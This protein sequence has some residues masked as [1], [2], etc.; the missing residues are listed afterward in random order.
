MYA[1]QYY[2]T[3][4][5]DELTRV[6]IPL[7]AAH[8]ETSTITHTETMTR[9]AR[10]SIVSLVP[11]TIGGGPIG[12]AAKQFQSLKNKQ[13]FLFCYYFSVLIDQAVH[14]SLREE[15]EHF[16]TLHSYPKFCGFLGSYHHNLHPALLLLIA[17]LYPN[18]ATEHETIATVDL[19][20]GYFRKNYISFF[21]DAYP[22]HSGRLTDSHQR[23]LYSR[24]QQQFR[25]STYL[26]GG[27]GTSPSLLNR[28]QPRLRDNHDSIAGT[29]LPSKDDRTD[30][31]GCTQKLRPSVTS[32]SPTD[33]H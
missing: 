9:G 11:E 17:T 27:L 2:E 20:A 10:I 30:L 15:H 26:R 29:T 3:S 5:S 18:D 6:A 7:L 23:V 25:A 13:L 28:C 1:V 12:A 24:S 31:N 32:K 4:F 8:H 21:A 16:D 33:Y 14:S 22:K 19:L